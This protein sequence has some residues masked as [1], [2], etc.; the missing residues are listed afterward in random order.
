MKTI[1]SPVKVSGLE[2]IDASKP[3]VYAVNHASALD[4]P[5][6][7]VY[8]PFLF[9]IV[10]KKR[11]VLLSDCRAGISSDPGRSASTNRSRPVPLAAFGQR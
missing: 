4:I 1:F 7:Y 10:F 11:T 8:L 5:V 6:L 2:K 9:R 3:H